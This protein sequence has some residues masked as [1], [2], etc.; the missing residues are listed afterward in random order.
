MNERNTSRA[1][2]ATLLVASM[3]VL[4]PAAV[5]QQPDKPASKR[6]DDAL[7]KELETDLLGDLPAAKK[8][9]PG[10]DGG[11]PSP[12]EQRLQD[13]LKA[14]E[15]LGSAPENPLLL[16]GRQMR[17]AQQRIAQKDTSDET[18]SVQGEIIDELKKL[19]EQ[20]KKQGGSGN[21]TTRGRGTG[22]GGP[23]DGQV[24]PGA[25]REATD[26]VGK[27]QTEATETADVRDLLQRI[28]GHLP[29]KRLDEMRNALSDQ[30][31]PKYEKLI[32]EYY[33]RLAEERSSSEFGVRNAE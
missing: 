14:G 13:D 19:I 15:D 2:L 26:R 28:W 30:F 24:Q 18:Q 16:I 20:A 31:L 6:A 8:T 29:Q 21:K 3:L 25:P 12:D 11:K 4:L 33:K 32:E 17:A 10:K 27:P 23:G 22:K 7:R 5:A 9:T 1:I